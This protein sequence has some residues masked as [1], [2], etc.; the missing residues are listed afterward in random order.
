MSVLPIPTRN[1]LDREKS[2]RSN[3]L[4]HLYGY[5]QKC[6]K[7]WSDMYAQSKGLTQPVFP[8]DSSF[9]STPISC[10]VVGAN[11]CK[12]SKDVHD[13]SNIQPQIC[14]V[15][16]TS[17][18]MYSEMM[19]RSSISCDQESANSLLFLLHH[20]QSLLVQKQLH[21]QFSL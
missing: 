20:L 11:G 5:I 18:E 10:E 6:L 12:W 21:L 15:I 2:G 19:E 17:R 3:A 13:V 14:A 8:A 4:S 7:R 9:S 16:R 1:K